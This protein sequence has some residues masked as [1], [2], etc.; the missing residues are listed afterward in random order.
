MPRPGQF[1][2]DGAKHID[3]DVDVHDRIEIER[4]VELHDGVLEC[5]DA[6]RARR[7][8]PFPGEFQRDP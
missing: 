5:R 3:H 6:P 1:I 7:I 4:I 8:E 2:H